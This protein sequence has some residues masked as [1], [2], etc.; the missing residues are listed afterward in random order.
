MPDL[1]TIQ[2]QLNYTHFWPKNPV[3]PGFISKPAI[4]LCQPRENMDNAMSYSKGV[5]ISPLSQNAAS[6]Y[7]STP[8]YHVYWQHY[9]A[10]YYPQG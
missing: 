8:F 2:L 6:L 5:E 1:G 3:N 10:G 4:L 7:A 9:G